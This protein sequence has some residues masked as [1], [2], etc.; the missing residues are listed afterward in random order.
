MPRH[1]AA[2]KAAAELEE[3]GQAAAARRSQEEDLAAA[4]A[5]AGARLAAW[6]LRADELAAAQAEVAELE[7]RL[8]AGEREL[9]V[10]DALFALEQAQH[11]GSSAPSEDS[12]DVGEAPRTRGLDAAHPAPQQACGV[13]MGLLACLPVP[14]C[15][16]GLPCAAGAH[17]CWP[18]L[19]EPGLRLPCPLP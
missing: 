4:L 1:P 12:E 13:G 8:F 9:L 18:P 11:G 7:G 5:A 17:C 3:A 6:Q 14:A 15:P 10:V 2:A 16:D 19:P